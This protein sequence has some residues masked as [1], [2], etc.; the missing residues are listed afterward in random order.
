[1]IVKC[2]RFYSLS[3][4]Y[5]L[6]ELGWEG[7]QVSECYCAYLFWPEEVIPWS[8]LKFILIVFVEFKILFLNSNSI[9]YISFNSIV[10]QKK[11]KFSELLL[12]P[13]ERLDDFKVEILKWAENLHWILVKI[14]LIGS[15]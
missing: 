5:L 10:F 3:K 6:F 11:W 7:V 9:K 12:K 15:Y 2:R 4:V 13:I 14:Q 1:M 8:H